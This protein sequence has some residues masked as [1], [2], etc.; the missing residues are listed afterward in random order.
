MMRVDRQPAETR[1]LCTVLLRLF[2]FTLGNPLHPVANYSTIFGIAPGERRRKESLYIIF[3]SDVE[4]VQSS[5]H[6]R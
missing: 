2:S 1:R 3:A 6:S 4:G 5:H